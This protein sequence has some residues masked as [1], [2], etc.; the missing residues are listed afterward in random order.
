MKNAIQQGE[1]RTR[2]KIKVRNLHLENLQNSIKQKILK[3]SFLLLQSTRCGQTK[4]KI[5]THYVKC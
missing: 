5:K 2:N 4:K 1:K 3:T